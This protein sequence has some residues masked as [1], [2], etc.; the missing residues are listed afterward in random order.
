MSN[1]SASSIPANRSVIPPPPAFVQ[2]NHT[3]APS[4]HSASATFNMP[5][6]Q[7]YNPHQHRHQNQTSHNTNISV[8]SNTDRQQQ[9]THNNYGKN[10]LPSNILGASKNYQQLQNQSSNSDSLPS[11]RMVQQPRNQSG[12]ISSKAPSAT[13]RPTSSYGRR[14]TLGS[15]NPINAGQNDNGSSHLSSV[16]SAPTTSGQSTYH[17][18]NDNNNKNHGSRISMEQNNNQPQHQRQPLSANTSHSSS[19]NTK[20]HVV[21]QTPSTYGNNSNSN[22]YSNAQHKRPPLGAIAHNQTANSFSS[23]SSAKRPK[24]RHH[25]PYNQ[26]LGGRKSI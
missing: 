8:S 15:N 11:N 21:S 25:N 18:N 19:G 23:E 9:Q 10:V 13:V 16:M 5:P 6:P 26:H 14:P 2:N 24:Q 4:I 22:S 17:D 7:Y 3:S 1:A 12:V 20:A